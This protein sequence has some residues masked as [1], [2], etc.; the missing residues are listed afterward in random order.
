MNNTTNYMLSPNSTPDLLDNETLEKMPVKN[1]V[2]QFEGNLLKEGASKTQPIPI[3]V[4]RIVMGDSEAETVSVELE[5]YNRLKKKYVTTTL[6]LQNLDLSHL[7]KV[8]FANAASV[9]CTNNT[10][11]QLNLDVNKMLGLDALPISRTHSKIGFSNEDGEVAFKGERIITK[12]N[13]ILSEYV[14][15]YDIKP[16][17]NLEAFKNMVQ[18]EIIEQDDFSPLQYVLSLGVSA[19][20][21]AYANEVWNDI[22]TNP[23]HHLVG[24]STTGKTTAVMLAVSLGSN[25]NSQDGFFITFNGT[26]NA[27]VKRIGY[28]H[29]FPVA[30]DEFSS[31]RLAGISQFLYTIANSKEAD[32]LG[33]GG[34]KLQ[35]AVNFVTTF[36]ST[37]E[38]SILSK[39]DKATGLSVRCTEYFNVEWT[40]SAE[41]AENIKSVCSSNYGLITPLVAEE[42]IKNDEYWHDRFNYWKEAIRKKI[43]DEDIILGVGD[44]LS[45]FVALYTTS[46][47][48]FNKAT[49]L[50]LDVAKVMEY[51]F[52]HIIMTNAESRNIGT[53]AYDKVCEYISKYREMFAMKCN[54][55]TYMTMSKDLIGFFD[56]SVNKKRI[57]GVIYD[58][59]C[60]MPEDIFIGVLANYQFNEPNIVLKQL[61]EQHF[62]LTKDARRYYKEYIINENKV[63]CIAIYYHDYQ[64]DAIM[65]MISP[66]EDKDDAIEMGE[67]LGLDAEN[68]VTA[69]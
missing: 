32:R 54:S 48:L 66:S 41:Q 16:S 51:G 62:L 47:E 3:K 12:Q 13:I 49:H 34:A 37:G 35:E 18:K 45:S 56:D 67:L 40:S 55:G 19:T 4:S 53:R 29:G 69:M 33:A 24:D 21:I 36:L 59:V 28:N 58:Q 2:I 52:E 57:A 17:G 9:E 38:K 64:N 43:K 20:L 15:R 5:V 22:I 65:Q 14:G 42:L 50:Q 68:T 31:N 30:F 7:R 61:K 44:R 26:L 10:V 27:L 1:G 60:V 23:F 11:K 6:P 39:T 8:V 63:R 46:A 25:P